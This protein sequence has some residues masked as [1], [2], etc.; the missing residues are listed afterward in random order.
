MQILRVIEAYCW[1]KNQ[2][3]TI[4]PTSSES[5]IYFFPITFNVYQAYLKEFYDKYL[6]ESVTTKR[7]LSH[8]KGVKIGVGGEGMSPYPALNS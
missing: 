7:Q 3:Q 8:L 6:L 5:S 1:T 4:A 2:R